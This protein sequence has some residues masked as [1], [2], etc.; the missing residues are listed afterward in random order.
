MVRRRLLSAEHNLCR[1]FPAVDCKL[2]FILSAGVSGAGMCGKGIH[3]YMQSESCRWLLE[4]FLVFVSVTPVFFFWT[5]VDGAR[6]VLPRYSRIYLPSSA[7]VHRYRKHHIGGAGAQRR[8]GRL[9]GGG[10]QHARR[11]SAFVPC[12]R[13]S[14]VTSFISSMSSCSD[15]AGMIGGY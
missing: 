15:S 7:C 2:R 8:G 14:C 5:D 4:I 6:I 11:T 13:V 12:T 10:H 9:A 3:T 1:S